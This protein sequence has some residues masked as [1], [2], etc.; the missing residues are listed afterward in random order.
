MAVHTVFSHKPIFNPSVILATP[1]VAAVLHYPWGGSST[2]LPLGWQQYYTTLGWQQYYTTPGV[3]AV[4]HYPWG[5]SSTTL[6]LGSGSSTTLPTGVAAVLHYPW[7][8]SSTTLPLGQINLLK[9]GFIS[10]SKCGCSLNHL[11]FVP[12]P[13]LVDVFLGTRHTHAQTSEYS[14]EIL[15]ITRPTSDDRATTD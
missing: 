6:P 5:G 3:A 12:L 14:L 15:I 1:G 11:Y 8:G 2:T 13:V 9:R 4:L 7:G 10:S